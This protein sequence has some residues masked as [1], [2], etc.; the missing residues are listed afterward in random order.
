MIEQASSKIGKAFRKKI[1]EFYNSFNVD[2]DYYLKN[3]INEK[4]KNM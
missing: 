3:N 1:C 4:L 2:L